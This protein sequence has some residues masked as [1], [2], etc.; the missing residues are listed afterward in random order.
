M[1]QLFGC[2]V[3]GRLPQNNAEQ[4][5]ETRFSLVIEDAASVNHLTIFLTK[6]EFKL[7]IMKCCY[8]LKCVDFLFEIS[9]FFLFFK[10]ALPDGF[11]AAVFYSWPPHDDWQYLGVL[12][13]E[14]PSAIFKL[15]RRGFPGMFNEQGELVSVPCVLGFS[16]EST[17]DIADIVQANEV[18]HSLATSVQSSVEFAEKLLISFHNFASSFAKE[19]PQTTEKIIP[20]SVLANWCKKLNSI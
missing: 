2:I 1:S 15:L 7:L 5:E 8:Y 13:N 3:A 18:E 20:L 4:I 17:A 6:C 9:F 19:I 16:L 11:G 14:K 12:T 10:S